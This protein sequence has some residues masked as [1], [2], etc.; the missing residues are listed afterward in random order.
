MVQHYLVTF[1]FMISMVSSAFSGRDCTTPGCQFQFHAS[2][3]NPAGPTRNTSPRYPNDYAK[4]FYCDA[5]W[6]TNSLDQPI[7]LYFQIEGTDVDAINELHC[8]AI[9]D[10]SDGSEPPDPVEDFW[11]DYE[12]TP[13]HP[14]QIY[15]SDC[16][17]CELSETETGM[18]WLIADTFR[19]D[20]TFQ[21]VQSDGIPLTARNMGYTEADLGRCITLTFRI[22]YEESLNWT[23]IH[24]QDAKIYI[25]TEPLPKL[26]NWYLGDTHTHT[27]SSYYFLEM[28][29]SGLMMFRS[30]QTSGLDWQ[31]VSDHAF[32]LTDQKWA[33]ITQECQQ[34]SIPGQFIALRGEECDDGYT[35][36]ASHHF[37]AFNLQSFISTYEDDPPVSESLQEISDQGGFAYGAHTSDDDWPWTDQEIL[38]AL[39]FNCFRGVEDYNSRNAYA[40]EDILHPWGVSPATGTWDETNPSWDSALLSGIQRWDRVL[41]QILESPRWECFFMGGSDAHG[42]MN[43]YVDWDVLRRDERTVD[44]NSRD[45]LY[46]AYS[47]ALGKVRTAAYCPEGLSTDSLLD[48]LYNGRTV[49]TDGPMIVIGI[50][51][52]SAPLSYSDCDLKIGDSDSIPI[53]SQGY[54]FVEWTSSQDYGS[55]SAI[56]I[57]LGDTASADN[58]MIIASLPLTDGFH[59]SQLIPLNQILDPVYNDGDSE[60]DFYVRAEAYTYDPETGPD[61]PGDVT[62]PDFDPIGSMYQF[63]ALTNPIWINVT[64]ISP[65][66]TPTRT[67]TPSPSWTPAPSSPTPSPSSSATPSSTSTPSVT[68]TPTSTATLFATSTPTS[69]ITPSPTRTTS[70]IPTATPSATYSS[71]AT[72]T[73]SPTA[74][75]TPSSSPSPAFSPTPPVPTSTPIPTATPD[76]TSTATQPPVP[77]ASHTPSVGCDTIR[78]SIELT[79]TVFHPGDSFELAVSVCAAPEWIGRE[80]P[81]FVILDVYGMYFYAPGFSSF[82]HLNHR[83]STADDRIIV[84]PSFPWPSD[85]GTADDIQLYAAFTN[86]EITRIEGEWDQVSFGWSDRF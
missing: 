19:S 1:I 2:E 40:S 34:G 81:L 55:V 61:A 33:T 66:V 47:S 80:R 65:T 7:P 6:R 60:P 49:V 29:A 27:W 10:V 13:D 51:R 44:I 26:E 77:T 30:M 38:D 8:I 85:C 70:P 67:S 28:G 23:D 57:L 18:F 41:S 50:N 25:G 36:D 58:P 3:C 52:S 39:A 35:L 83:F 42:S 64:G 31:L 45:V 4:T 21:G 20:G 46:V 74:T 5:P 82:D 78:A 16:L 56:R 15:K 37:L 62:I 54:L 17:G 63:R 71:T 22:I 75:S 48:A 84:I 68:S 12:Y 32:N 59:G 73:P 79:G 14:N 86:A 72:S 9:Y 69:T 11:G 24:D 43:Y 53:D 76:P